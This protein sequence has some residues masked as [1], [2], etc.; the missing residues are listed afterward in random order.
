MGGDRMTLR[1]ADVETL[2]LTFLDHWNQQDAAG[3]AALCVPHAYVIG[4]DGSELNG[5]DAIEAELRRIFAQH[6][7]PSYVAK[8][9]SVEL[10]EDVAILRAVVGMI[11]PGADDLN[12]EL[13]AIQTFVTSRQAGRWKV[14]V[15]QNTPAAFHG[16]SE[17]RERLTAELRDVL[18]VARR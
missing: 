12:P 7:T 18:R 16:R 15:L 14:E 11:P 8:V 10:F 13:N 3:M 5:R 4:F 2:Y 1:E 6:K 9:R 17:A